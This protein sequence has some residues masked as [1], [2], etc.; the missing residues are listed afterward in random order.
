MPRNT[1]ELV[2]FRIGNE[3]ETLAVD[4]NLCG[5]RGCGSESV[6]RFVLA[7]NE[8]LERNEWNSLRSCPRRFWIFWLA[9]ST[10]LPF[11]SF[12]HVCLTQMLDRNPSHTGLPHAL[13]PLLL[14]TIEDVMVGEVMSLRKMKD[15]QSP[16]LEVSWMLK[17]ESWRK[18][19]LT[20][21]EPRSERSSPYCK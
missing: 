15:D 20:N 4:E 10:G 16:S 19:S 14:D 3:P 9:W 8:L 1:E 18:N 6:G 7:R 5:T 11:L 13:V 21:Q 2:D 12:Q 17:R